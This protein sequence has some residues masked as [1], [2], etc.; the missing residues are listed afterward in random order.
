MSTVNNGESVFSDSFKLRNPNPYNKYNIYLNMESNSLTY[1]MVEG[2]V[3]KFSFTFDGSTGTHV[4]NYDR[5]DS[6]NCD[7]MGF[8][9]HK[10][11]KHVTLGIKVLRELNKVVG[12]NLDA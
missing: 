7:C 12:E 5:V 1:K 11:C 9:A 3:K 8:I 2:R 10:K 6:W 4:V